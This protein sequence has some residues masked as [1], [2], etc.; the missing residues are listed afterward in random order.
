MQAE[1][2]WIGKGQLWQMKEATGFQKVG[3]QT[4]HKLMERQESSRSC[5]EWREGFV[6]FEAVEVSYL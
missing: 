4:E 2:N 1:Q 6:L 3:S 5:N